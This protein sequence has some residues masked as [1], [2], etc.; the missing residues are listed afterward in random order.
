MTMAM[1][2]ETYY[3]LLHTRNASNI[4]HL[5]YTASEKKPIYFEYNYYGDDDEDVVYNIRVLGALY[6]GY[7]PC[8]WCCV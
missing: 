1:A 3:F 6:Y 5:N 2:M 4:W 7:A 8:T